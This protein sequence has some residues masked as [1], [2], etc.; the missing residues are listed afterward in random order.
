M[1]ALYET[2]VRPVL[3]KGD[4]EDVHDRSISCLRLLGRIKPLVRLMAKYNQAN[5]GVPIS[6]F[7]LKFPNAVGLA[8]GFDKNALCWDV[9]EA[10]GFGH[11]E[12]GTVTL[13]EQPGNPRPR[14]FRYP[15]EEAVINRMGFPN[16]G[17]EKIAKRLS[18]SG[19]PRRRR[20]PLGINIGKSRVASLEQAVDDYLGSYQLLADYADYFAINVSSPN[21]P[22]LRKLQQSDHLRTLLGALQK[23]DQ[24][25]SRKLGKPRIPMLVKIAP[26][27]T[28]YQIDEILEIVEE[29]GYAGVIATN[30]TIDRPGVFA[31]ISETGGLS[32][33]PLLSKTSVIINY[34]HRATCGKVPIIGVG[35][36]VDERSAGVIMDAGASLV[37]VYTG[38][39]FRGPFFARDVARALRWRQM[40]WI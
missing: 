38:M 10:L 18:K 36:I 20:F 37:Q 32:G 30:T 31:N 13:H 3:F 16:D 27:L 34:I 8:A 1:G 24:E 19:D 22:E 40:D 28:F 39:V 29:L 12:I 4:P 6:L 35:G 23:A 17:A 11:V 15:A 14:I 7:G 25:R 33:R 5:Q 21:T 2:I 26:D 9:M